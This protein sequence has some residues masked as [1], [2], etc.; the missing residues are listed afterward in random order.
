MKVVGLSQRVEPLAPHEDGY[1]ALQ[2]S[3]IRR[4]RRVI[5][6]T[7]DEPIDEEGE[8]TTEKKV[9]VAVVDVDHGAAKKKLLGK[10]AFRGLGHRHRVD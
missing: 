2:Q 1:S 7:V 5:E 9:E 6:E 3:P 4:K 10:S 8:G